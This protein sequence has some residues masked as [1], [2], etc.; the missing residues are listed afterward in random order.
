MSC[1][2]LLAC[3][4]S[5]ER[6]AVNH[7]GVPLYATCCFSLAAF[8]ILS[9]CLVFIIAFSYYSLTVLLGVCFVHHS[10]SNEPSWVSAEKLPVLTAC[11][12]LGKSSHWLSWWKNRC[13]L[14]PEASGQSFPGGSDR[15][16]CLQCGRPR[17]DSWVGKMFWR[18]K[19]QP[20]PVFL[21]EKIPWMKEPG[22][23]QFMR[24]QTIG[25]DWVTNT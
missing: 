24:L 20:T 6:S 10:K 25:H 22:G 14:R 15:R 4:V 9:L 23:L 17:F 3:R 21:P 5:A 2:S 19:W 8:N 12:T 11:H 1:H 18:K 13:S 7:V 16:V